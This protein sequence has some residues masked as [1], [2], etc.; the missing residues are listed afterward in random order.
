MS[1]SFLWNNLLVG[2]ADILQK[3]FSC[4]FEFLSIFRDSFRVLR[5]FVS[6]FRNVIDIMRAL[7]RQYFVTM[8]QD[9][10]GNCLRRLTKLTQKVD[11]RNG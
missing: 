4:C 10:C 6:S 5:A 9:T 11:I 8:L 3:Y 2:F 7:L 1:S